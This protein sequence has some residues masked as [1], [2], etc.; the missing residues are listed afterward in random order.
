MNTDPSGAIFCFF[1][2]FVHLVDDKLNVIAREFISPH[3][4][5][6]F[7]IGSIKGS[8]RCGDALHRTGIAEGAPGTE[9]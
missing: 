8:D 2:N 7:F 6:D 4:Q 5:T 1:I 3:V 9:P